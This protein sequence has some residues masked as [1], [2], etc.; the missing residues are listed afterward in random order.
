MSMQTPRDVPSAYSVQELHQMIESNEYGPAVAE[1]AVDRIVEVAS[2]RTQARAE[3]ALDAVQND[4]LVF[5]TWDSY[6]REKFGSA[7]TEGK[8]F[9]NR[10]ALAVP[11]FRV[12]MTKDAWLC[13]DA[14]ALDH[15]WLE[16]GDGRRSKL[17]T[18]DQT[19]KSHCDEQGV[20]WAPKDYVSLIGLSD[21]L[22]RDSPSVSDAM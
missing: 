1:V 18:I 2:S 10:F 13:K 15:V 8:S 9:P 21:E 17:Q 3:G 5:T 14:V 7:A 11:D 12:S 19:D 20:F 4:C 16:N 22:V 6:C